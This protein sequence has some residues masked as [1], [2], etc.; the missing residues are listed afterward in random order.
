M[1]DIAVIINNKAK[2]AH[3]L[4]KYLQGF[5]QH[6][7][8]YQL[9]KTTP[10]NLE[11][12]IKQCRANHPILLVGGGDGTIRSAAQWCAHTSTLLGVLPLGTMNHFA[13]EVGLPLTV[14]DLIEAIKKRT[15][16][17]IDL[18]EVNGN[19]F[20]NNSSIGFYPKLAQKRDYYTKFYNKWLSYIPS[21]IQA[22][23]YHRSYSL[24]VKSKEFNLLLKTS[25]FMISNNPYSYEFPLKF[26]RESF[27]EGL[28]GI[29][30]FKHGRL[31]F[32]EILRALFTKKHNFD[33][34]QASCPIELTIHHKEKIIISLD[35]DTMTVQTPLHYKSLPKS[36]LL[37]T[38]NHENNSHL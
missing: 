23:F 26:T 11:Q 28:L 6:K 30:Y 34:K 32:F 15:T 21:F 7:L 17:L 3:Q 29:Y 20:I 8:D 31:R 10:K 35:G 14:D 1:V 9:Y 18:A 37:L 22:L 25:F 12:T 16:T 36:L 27:K 2:N 33:I 19:V 24:L 13:K 4:E 5:T 38:N